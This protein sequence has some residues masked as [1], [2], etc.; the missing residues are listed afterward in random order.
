MKKSTLVMILCLVLAVALGVGGTLA[1]LT[2]SDGDVNVMTVGH[3]T[4]TQNEQERV[5]IG[6]PDA[7]LDE[8]T[9]NKPMN[10]AVSTD[11]SSK[12]TVNVNGWEVKIRDQVKNYVDKIVSVTNT[13]AND[14]YVR[15]IFAFP[16]A[17]DFDTT[18]N[19]S[20]QWFHW[21]GV[22]DTDTTP[23]NG[24]IWGADEKTEWPG[25]NEGWDVYENVTIDG[26]VYDI[27]VVTNKNVLKKGETT[28]PS[29]LG[30]YLDPRVDC[31]VNP[32]TGEKNYTF[33]AAD[34]TEY[35]LGDI[36]TLEVLVLSQAVQAD[37]FD[38]AWEAFD[39]A[40]P[41]DEDALVEWLGEIE[42]GTPGE[43]WPSNNPPSF[44]PEGAKTI[45]NA[46][47]L[48]A[49]IAEGGE[50]YLAQNIDL[51]DKPIVVNDGAT[52]IYMNGK[53]IKSTSTASTTSQ[54]IEVKN[55]AT[56]ELKGEGLVTFAA[57]KPDTEWGGEGQPAFPGYANNTIKN[58]GKLVIDGPTVENKT[59]AGGAS[60]AIDCYP[61]SDLILESGEIKG[62]D[63]VAI[64]MFASSNTMNT[65][66]TINGGEVSGRRGIW[67]QLPTSKVSDKGMA[68]LTVTG[69]TITS[70]QP[71]S[72]LAIYSYSYGESFANTNVTISGGTF[73]GTVGFG[74]GYK[75]D[76]ENVTVSGGTFN[77]GIGRYLADD[78]WEDIAY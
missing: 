24:W 53:T 4:I 14:A 35:D 51:N 25:N 72:D 66:V 56:L 54:G 76:Q 27:Y 34:G 73:N 6:N 38:S 64:R 42:V 74:G 63:K 26:T 43:K 59:Q 32:V 52:T 33:K 15:T 57:T 29:L 68:T 11:G 46:E 44:I 36:S 1:Y 30:M 8:F 60:Y 69:G 78:G 39:A 75:G 61:G 40:F 67:I 58:A 19:A 70:L 5:E 7:G 13:G 22:S 28:A 17:G 48:A 41:T 2:D 37:G 55:G 10:P 3:V 62:Y 9:Q 71:E 16:E 47:E 31:D 23:A 45:N 12:E 20:E 77:G 21:N 18:Y 49:A 65:A 50:Y